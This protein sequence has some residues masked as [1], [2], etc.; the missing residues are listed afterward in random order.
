LK[1]E[2]VLDGG[3]DESTSGIDPKEDANS[4]NRPCFFRTTS[5]AIYLGATDNGG[6]RQPKG[7]EEEAFRWVDK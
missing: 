7:A 6:D 2:P 5:N 1:E 4:D 3:V